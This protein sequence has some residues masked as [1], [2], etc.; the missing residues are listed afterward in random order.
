MSWFKI[1]CSGML[2]VSA[3]VSIPSRGEERG[4]PILER[5]V[6]DF[7][8][9]GGTDLAFRDPR[10]G[11][12]NAFFRFEMRSRNPRVVEVHLEIG[13][14]VAPDTITFALLVSRI[15]VSFLDR[16]GRSVGE[17]DLQGESLWPGGLFVI[18]DSDDGYFQV[19]ETLRGVGRA[20]RAVVRIFGNYE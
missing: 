19:R 6:F 14:H 10:L 13:R 11:N 7:G 15:R 2:I 17:V 18:G 3:F 16:T 5:Y 1:A 20:R 12:G 8:S 4:F 9:S